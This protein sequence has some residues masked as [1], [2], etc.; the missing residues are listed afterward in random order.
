MSR[1]QRRALE[2][3]QSKMSQR[4]RRVAGASGAALTISAYLIAAADPAVA[5]SIQVT[6]TADSAPGAGSVL[7]WDD[8][9]QV[10][11]REAVE[12]ANFLSGADT[13]DFALGLN[14]TIVLTNGAISISDGVAIDGTGNAITVS[15]NNTS[16]VFAINTAASTAPAVTLSTLT[17]TAGRTADEGGAIR[18]VGGRLDLAGMTI[19]NSSATFAGGGLF[20]NAPAQLHITDSLITGNVAHES[21]GGQ[22]VQGGGVRIANVS[23]PV[24]LSRTRLTGNTVDAD[25]AGNAS[26]GGIGNGGGLSATLPSGTSLSITNDTGNNAA[27][28]VSGNTVHVDPN[29]HNQGLGGGIWVRGT[30]PESNE[31]DVDVTIQNTDVTN[32]VSDG[33]GG[34]IY[35]TDLRAF[36]LTGSSLQSN[37]A[38]GNAAYGGYGGSSGAGGGGYLNRLAA[39]L[40]ND[41][42]VG[43]EARNGGGIFS[44]DSHLSVTNTSVTGN[45]AAGY[46]G[47]LAVVRQPDPTVNTIA[48]ST[49]SN[50]TSNGDGGGIAAVQTLLNTTSSTVTN[51]TSSGGS[52]GGIAYSQSGGTV[53]ATQVGG[54]TS[55]G[56]GGGIAVVGDFGNGK[57]V[58]IH[59]S[60]V[61]TN[62]TVSGDGGGISLVNWKGDV[63]NATVSSNTASSP[64]GEGGG[65]FV[66]GPGGTA[67]TARSGRILQTTIASNQSGDDGPGVY[68]TNTGPFT[69]RDSLIGDNDRSAVTGA[70]DIESGVTE[71]ATFALNYTLVERAGTAPIVAGGTGNIFDQDPALGPLANNGGRPQL[72][73]RLPADTSPAVDAGD[74]NYQGQ[75][76]D[77]RGTGFPRVV[78]RLT[79]TARIDMGAL[80]V[81]Q[82]PPASPSPSPSPAVVTPPA[83]SPSPSATV[84]GRFRALLSPVRVLD[85]RNGTGT[86]TG[87]KTGQVVVDLSSAVPAGTTSVVL[88]VTVTGAD[89]EGHVVGYPFGTTLPRTSNVNFTAGQTQANEVVVALSSDRKLI[90]EVVGAHTQ[91]VADLVGFFNNTGT[92]GSAQNGGEVRSQTPT[93]LLDTRETSQILRRGAITLDLTGQIP[94]G[95]TAA[96]LNLTI[97]RPEGTGFAVVYAAGTTKPGTSN[98]NFVRGQQQANEAFVRLGTGADKNKVTISLEGADTALVVDLV[99]TVGPDG[100]DA[101]PGGTGAGDFTALKDPVRAVDTRDGTGGISGRITGTRV[102][103]LPASAVPAGAR[104][105]L[106]NV[107]A[108]GPNK[109]GWVAVYPGGAP[110]PPTSSVNF[111][112]GSIQANAVITGLG[113]GNT[114]TVTVGGR[115][116]PETNLIVDVVGFLID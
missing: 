56:N 66:Q 32:N 91:L 58:D 71:D 111:A 69:I 37:D 7:D 63:V 12:R 113:T 108:V 13:I 94:D 67:G 53:D 96:V 28:V 99:A 60:T 8:D 85:S 92:P 31:G 97:T 82:P 61:S 19:Q 47:G 75:Q 65:I 39:T 5:A 16:R 101:A 62:R 100:T 20:F 64:A 112:P 76:F 45:T 51:N 74:P 72:L 44:V 35:A 105:V 88:N 2:R 57:L 84:R 106:L 3:K 23:G 4:A 1:Q 41:S 18:A 29:V 42:V 115:D 15:G 70:S 102:L 104:A 55:N 33:H 27:S 30:G 11:L 78:A 17:L 68:I 80:E 10:T 114:V 24:T 46:G 43:D 107:T 109:I 110:Q 83:P 40:T 36:T 9:G 98:V 116:A 21:G 54:N 86:A 6:T 25:S 49:I 52:G 38:D 48:G 73:T 93:R 89:H 22:I 79:A 34:G 50:N 95:S 81:Q 59:D 26:Y 77:Q 103:T 87:A 14:G 90:L